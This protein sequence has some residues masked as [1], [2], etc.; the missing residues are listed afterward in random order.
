MRKGAEVSEQ[1]WLARRPTTLHCA[2]NVKQGNLGRCHPGPVINDDTVRRGRPVDI[3]YCTL[4]NEAGA[5]ETPT[6]HTKRRAPSPFAR[7]IHPE[8]G[9]G[10]ESTLHP[11]RSQ[12]EATVKAGW[13][14]M[15]VHTLKREPVSQKEK[16]QIL[17]AKHSFQGPVMFTHYHKLSLDSIGR[18]EASFTVPAVASKTPPPTRPFP[19]QQS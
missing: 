14:Q 8:T 3:H 4:L 18:G 11:A 10:L 17:E 6:T 15:I 9:F 5:T 2:L 16:P 7:G 12:T 13:Q 19:S 1:T